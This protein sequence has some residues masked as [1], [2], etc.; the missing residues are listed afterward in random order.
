MKLLD[1]AALQSISGGTE[2]YPDNG[3]DP[4]GGGGGGGGAF[5][6]GGGGAITPDGIPVVTIFGT[7][8]MVEGARADYATFQQVS[9]FVAAAAGI[10][11]AAA[12]TGACIAIPSALSGPA[13]PEVAA[14]LSRPC[15]YVGSLSGTMA[16]IWVN[17]VLKMGLDLL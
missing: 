9:A 14:L 6:G 13:A 3:E 17:G 7:R 10:G 4:I 11:A 5:P 15:V 1:C 2:Y 8:D 12:T 16:G